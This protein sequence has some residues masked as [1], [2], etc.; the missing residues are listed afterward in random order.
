MGTNNPQEN[1]IPLY[2]AVP[3]ACS[4]LEGQE[5]LNAFVD[6]RWTPDAKGYQALIDAGFR[7]SGDYLY[8]PRCHNCRACLASRIAVG[9]FKPN[10]SQKR[11]MAKNADLLISRSPARHSAEHFELYRQY[12]NTRH[13]G[14]GMENP[15]PSSFSSF[16]F[17]PWSHT[18]FI[19][20]RAP[21]GELLAVAVI[22]NLLHG[23]SAVYTFFNPE[24]EARSLGTFAILTQIRLAEE[25][26][27]DFVYLGF[28]IAESPK[29]AYKSNFKPLQIFKDGHWEN[30]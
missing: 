12:L 17:A 24:A 30:A 29:M 14:G 22:D 1:R 2:A 4:Y 26:N 10:R 15:E 21:D 9:A 19:D 3:Q 5:A 11:C 28:W 6:P 27:K 7:R 18:E 8:S 16:L 25:D 13:A 23:Y 20:F